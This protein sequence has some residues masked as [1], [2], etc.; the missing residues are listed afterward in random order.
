MATEDRYLAQLNDIA[1]IVES[2]LV[3]QLRYW[4]LRQDRSFKVRPKEPVKLWIVLIEQLLR[5]QSLI[6]RRIVHQGDSIVLHIVL[7][8]HDDLDGL[9][10][11]LVLIIVV[12]VDLV[13]EHV[14][15]L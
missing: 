11:L 2:R 10:L 15:Q 6:K 3:N 9:W 13:R 4:R 8:E 14:E 7:V 1:L 5:L 12:F